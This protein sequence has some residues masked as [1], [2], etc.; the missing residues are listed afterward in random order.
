MKIRQLQVQIGSNGFSLITTVLA[1]L[2]VLGSIFTVA[3]IAK[4]QADLKQEA[5]RI[6]AIK[7]NTEQAVENAQDDTVPEMQKNADK[8]GQE[9]TMFSGTVLSGKKS[10][11]LDFN[12]ADYDAA[13]RTEKLI[14]IY[15][16]AD[17]CPICQAELPN[18]YA[19]FN[20]LDTDET[21]GFRVNFNDDQTDPDEKILA[22]E[23]GVSYQ[24]TKIFISRGRKVLKAEEP[25]QKN[26]Y[27]EKIKEFI[28]K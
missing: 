27:L 12:K 19:A 28:D 16:Y 13:L 8:P 14:V 7:A 25:W 23:F 21:T 24:H 20:E 22:R 18:I 10:K 11:L 5:L 4:R 17:W 9:E 15:F 26:Q 2:I 1:G 6:S 3:A